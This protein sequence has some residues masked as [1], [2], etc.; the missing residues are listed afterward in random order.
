LTDIIATHKS[1]REKAKKYIDEVGI[2]Y[3]I[4]HVMSLPE[5]LQ[6]YVY[7]A[8]IQ[9]YKD[10]HQDENVSE[11]ERNEAIL[12]EADLVNRFSL[13]TRVWGQANSAVRDVYNQFD[14]AFSEKDL[15]DRFTAANGGVITEEQKDT[16]KDQAKRINELGKEIRDLE[17]RLK[18]EQES[19]AFDAILASMKMKDD[20]YGERKARMAKNI[21]IIARNI[22]ALLEVQGDKRESTI[23]AVAELGKDLIEGG[24]AQ[25]GD[26]IKKIKEILSSKGKELPKQ[27]EKEILDRILETTNI[28]NE[29]VVITRQGLLSL[30]EAGANTLDKLVEAAKEKYFYDNENVTDRDI[31]DA[32]TNYGKSKMSSK[33]DIEKELDR[34]K[35]IGRLMSAIED[36]QK[37]ERPK[38]TG[39]IRTE[40]SIQAKDLRKQLNA[41]LEQFGL[42]D[43]SKVLSSREDR[44]LKTLQRNIQEV[45]AQIKGKAIDIK[46]NRKTTENKDIIDLRK[47][48]A[49]L[50]KDEVFLLANAKKNVDRNIL[51]LKQRLANKDYSVKTRRVSPTDQELRNKIADKEKL[52]NEVIANRYKAELDQRTK[53]QKAVDFIWKEINTIPR[54]FTL[55]LLDI[56][57][58]GVQGGWIG[59][60]HPIRT[61][62]A[63]KD[64]F[65]Q[66]GKMSDSDFTEWKAKIAQNPLFDVMKASGLKL[67]TLNGK[68]DIHEDVFVKSVLNKGLSKLKIDFPS[69]N[70]RFS[71]MF[72]TYQRMAMMEAAISNL[73]SQGKTINEDKKDFEAVADVINTYTGAATLGGLEKLKLTNALV[74]SIRNTASIIKMSPLGTAYMTIKLKDNP[75]ALK[76][77]WATQARH[78]VGNAILVGAMY[79][80]L[81]QLGD[82]DDEWTMGTDPRAT[83]FGKLKKGDITV[84]D[85]GGVISALVLQAR[86]LILIGNYIKVTEMKNYV[87]RKGKEQ[88]SGE[89]MGTYVVPKGIDLLFQWIAGRLSPLA[90]PFSK[91]ALSEYKDGKRVYF[92][93]ELTLENTIKNMF[94]PIGIETWKDLQD[95]KDKGKI[96]SFEQF[97]LS[98]TQGMGQSVNTVSYDD[99]TKQQR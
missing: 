49:E 8:G 39:I 43:N 6:V 80:I 5:T 76:L 55:G 59:L 16:L 70:Q 69:T 24:F 53:F 44:I 1:L 40:P 31:R 46:S 27:Y 37:G 61:A 13:A 58:I 57:Y 71:T 54:L 90:Q 85:W 34:M 9:K 65:T 52:K 84:G 38:T 92:N 48:L 68:E 74:T 98:A 50:K 35:T 33:T 19:D 23:N 56:G 62:K 83:N 79:G 82:D 17:K 78:F 86:E 67:P 47:K 14:F 15:I 93:E 21:D 81:S 4:D 26:V 41:L 73:N 89:K 72:L 87:T 3:A 32:I 63:F 94:S 36:A 99:K 91:L 45:E 75:Q 66:T 88:M 25:F 11:Q 2:D 51:Y 20:S 7:G 42:R 30:I 10:I 96:N 12:L 28:G 29:N 64:A 97:L 60:S 77:Y 22:G 95:L 18:E